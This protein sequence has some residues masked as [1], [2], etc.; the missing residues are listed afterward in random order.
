[1]RKNAILILCLLLVPLMMVAHASA[2]DGNDSEERSLMA[3]GILSYLRGG[4]QG[5]PG[6]GELRQAASLY[7]EYPRSINDSAGN[8]FVFYQ[9]VQRVVVLNN[10][11]ADAMTAIGA[12]GVIVGIAESMT[13]N[14][15]QFPVTSTL[16]SVGK[17]MEPDIEAILALNPDLV[18]TYVKWPESAKLESHLPGRIPVVRMEF[19]KVQ[20]YR[21][22]M[23]TAGRLFNR[24]ENASKYL[25]WYDHYIILVN[26]RVQ[27]IP[28]EERVQVYAE[29]GQGQSFGRRVYSEGTG[30]DDLLVA[31]GGVNM[32]SGYVTGY[33]DVENEWVFYKKPEVVL[34]WSGKGGYK[35]DERDQVV[36]IYDGFTGIRGFGTL[37]AVSNMRVYVISSSFAYGSSFPASLVQVAAWLYP[38]RFEDIDPMALHREYLE[39][40]T[41]TSEEVWDAGTFYYPDG[42][43]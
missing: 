31:A 12:D 23:E 20:S 4:S 32:A 5:A 8:S 19:Y 22:E 27:D 42:R 37:P 7:P 17:W 11:A 10:N 40:Y 25:E 18:I 13:E 6:L 2:N 33:A 14:T 34:I 29:A 15:N 41:Q 26:E 43:E 36:A 9:P 21:E 1:M 35:T 38:D 16:P 24:E 39:N 28:Q 3:Q 30:L